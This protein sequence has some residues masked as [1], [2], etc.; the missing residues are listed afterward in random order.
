MIET[1]KDIPGYDG[2][3]QA[4]TEGNVRRVYKSGKTRQMTAYY[5]KR[6]GKRKLV[7]KLSKDG[8]AKEE[9]L[10]QVIARTFLGPVPEGCVTYHKNGCQSDNYVNNIAYIQRKELG[11]KTG[12]RSGSRSV[13]QINQNGEITEVYASAR[14]A[15]RKNFMS[16]QTVIDRCNGKCKSAFAPD[17]Y[18]Y[19]WEDKE[20]SIRQAVRKIKQE[21]SVKSRGIPDSQSRN[22][23][24]R[25]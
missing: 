18:A 4:D 5:K 22:R 7:V 2:K 15:G 25:R 17:G 8:K 1:W 20:S 19:A 13:F 14:E 24:F 10:M 21:Q 9:P 12:K 23:A 6:H 11:K 16:Y 3:Y